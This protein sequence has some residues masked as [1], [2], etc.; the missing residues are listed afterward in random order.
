MYYLHPRDECGRKREGLAVSEDGP[1]LID[2]NGSPVAS[3][4]AVDNIV[5]ISSVEQDELVAV[6]T[7]KEATQETVRR[8]LPVYQG[9]Y[10]DGF[11]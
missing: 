11:M 10:I 9:A 8:Q 7:P 6:T 1:N 3:D 4:N 2:H 5:E